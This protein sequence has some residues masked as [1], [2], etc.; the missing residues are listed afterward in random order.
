MMN[1]SETFNSEYTNVFLRNTPEPVYC[2]RSGLTVYEERFLDGTL[3]PGG[4][5]ASGYPLNVLSNYPTHIDNACV[6]EPASFHLE[7]DGETV[8]YGLSMKDFTV[9]KT[10]EGF[11]EA[12]LSLT[13]PVKPVEIKVHTLLDGTAM[14][15]RWLEVTNLSDKDIAVSRLSVFSGAIEQMK[16]FRANDP[17]AFPEDI[18]ELGYFD[19]DSWGKEG[20]LA[21]RPL[22]FDK[23]TISGRFGRMRYR[24]PAFFLK[25]KV[26]GLM[27]FGQLAWSAGYEFSFDYISAHDSKEATLV[28][29]MTVTG[30]KPLR[31]IAPGESFVSPR[32]HLGVVF[33]DLDSA[34]H[35]THEHVR[36][37][38]LN[39]PEAN[40]DACLIGAGMGPEHDMSVE[41]TK[42]FAAQMAELGAEIFIIDAGWYCPPDKETEWW[43]RAGDWHADPDRYPNGI[44]EVR[45]YI[46]SLGMKFAMWMESERVGNQAKCFEEHPDWFTKLPVGTTTPGFLDFTNPDAAAWAEEEIARVITEYQLDLFRIDYNIGS[47]QYF[48]LRHGTEGRTEYGAVKHYEAIYAMYRRLKKRFP[49]VIF[50]NCA[51]GGGRT[52]LG[53]LAAFNH[54]WVSDQ[55]NAPSSLY[56]TSGMTLV[57]PPER[58]DRLVA[59][60]GC[61]GHG[62][63]AL[64]M[65]NAMMG[66]LTL[67]VFSPAAA[68]YNPEQLAFIK[69]SVG[70]YKDFIRPMLPKASMYHYNAEVAKARKEG[71]QALQ[72]VSEDKMKSALTVFRLP[73][74]STAPV[75]IVPQGLSLDKK[76]KVTLDN[77]GSS[78]IVTGWELS[79]CGITTMPLSA[80]T[81]ELILIEAIDE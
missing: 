43:G 39:L 3:I 61:H 75:K 13:S 26:S 10:E 7:L 64:Q 47:A 17:D 25:N 12:V 20:S 22:P 74:A 55:Q 69:R 4:W 76:Y 24:H 1:Q 38:V 78:A 72:L 19:K 42:R 45:D 80:M 70:I 65:R 51:G 46:H 68:A 9:S 6:A 59:G 32:V 14:I 60:M 79:T 63:L 40:G 62:S 28:L 37:S 18:Y 71:Y 31:L 58:V 53:M 56:I 2:F 57:L 35:A 23:T 48:Y 29:E 73:G 5:N 8:D 77:T 11:E 33:G 41:T 21:W 27:F 30:H 15:T 67:N 54:S 16:D 36:R 81:S 44:K 52:D 49:D 66:H 34:V 50:E